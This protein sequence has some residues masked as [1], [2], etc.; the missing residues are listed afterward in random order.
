ML[1][2]VNFHHRSGKFTAMIILHFLKITC[3]QNS[4]ILLLGGHLLRALSKVETEEAGKKLIADTLKNGKA[5]QKFHDMIIA[6]GVQPGVAQKL[7]AAGADP[8][9]ILP[10]ASKKIE[11]VVEKSGIVSGIDALVMAKVTH[12]LGAGR[13]TAGDKVDHGVGLVLGIRVGQF[14]NKGDKWV[15]VYHNGNLG[16]SQKASLEKALEV[17]ENGG[18]VDLPAASRIIDI[19]DSKRRHSI[20]VCQ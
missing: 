12:E 19:I 5:L 6:Q 14:V 15:T 20:F 13:V 3:Y 16:D 17:D 8:F 18:T 7:C 9:S 1:I 2:A 4:N 10:L 11:L